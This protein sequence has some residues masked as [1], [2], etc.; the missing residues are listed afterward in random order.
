VLGLTINMFYMRFCLWDL[1][2][3]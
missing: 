1:H 3:I 2:T